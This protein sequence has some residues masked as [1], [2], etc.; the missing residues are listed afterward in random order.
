MRSHPVSGKYQHHSGQ[1]ISAPLGTPIYAVKS[2]VVSF[3]GDRGLGGGKEFHI[4]HDATHKTKY[5]HNDTI[6][7]TVGQSVTQGQQVSRMGNTGRSTGSHLH[8]TLSE[9]GTNI[10]PNKYFS[11]MAR[12]RRMTGKEPT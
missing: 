12:S 3:V 2:G 7:V 5:L 8:F 9:N 10:N 1:D 6:L 11:K 4:T